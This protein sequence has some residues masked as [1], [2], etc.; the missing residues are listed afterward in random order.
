MICSKAA[1]AGVA[2]C[3]LLAGCSGLAQSTSSCLAVQSSRV[4]RDARGP[5]KIYVANCAGFNV[6]TYTANKGKQTNPTIPSQ[7]LGY[8]PEDVAV[9][10]KGKIYVVGDYASLF[11]FK[12]NGKPTI[13]LGK[14][15]VAVT[16]DASGKIYI[17]SFESVQA[18]EPDGTPT[19]PTITGF[20]SAA[21][22]AVDANGKIY[23]SDQETGT[24]TTYTADGTP[25]TPT[26]SGL[27]SP[28]GVAVDANFKIYVVQQGLGEVTTYNSDGTP[29]TPTITGFVTPWSVAVS[30][31]GD[32]YV[33]ANNT[34]TTYNSDGAHIQ[35]TITQGLNTPVGLTLR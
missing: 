33:T 12:P 15:L 34:I 25:T 26:I 35:P 13:N 14:A 23:V 19:T 4:V 31:V 28:T 1:F 6:T 16:V 29:T 9:D 21:G 24:I 22:I 20:D 5:K 10:A 8:C 30:T 27:S 2:L 32:I 7:N 3:A 17:V 18:F 11:S